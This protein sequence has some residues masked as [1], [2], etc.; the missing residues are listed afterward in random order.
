[1]QDDPTCRTLTKT[2]LQRGFLVTNVPLPAATA[3]SGSAEEPGTSSTRQSLSS[4]G[5]CSLLNSFKATADDTCCRLQR[6]ETVDEGR[7]ADLR[8]FCI[9]FLVLKLRKTTRQV[10]E[11]TVH[12][13]LGEQGSTRVRL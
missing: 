6:G 8:N 11:L 4:T 13:S 5:K 7:L 12:E 3:T 10:R 1:M 2:L 9:A